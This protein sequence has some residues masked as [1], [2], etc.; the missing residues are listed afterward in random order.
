MF[1]VGAKH[2]IKMGRKETKNHITF[3]EAPDSGLKLAGNEKS[4]IWQRKYILIC[5]DVNKEMESHII[6]KVKCMSQI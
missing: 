5:F 4:V 1:C 6:L 2:V 3:A